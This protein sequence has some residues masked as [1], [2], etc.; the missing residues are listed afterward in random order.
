MLKSKKIL[1]LV[2]VLLVVI[3]IMTSQVKAT[4]DTLNLDD[5]LNSNSTANTTSNEVENTVANTDSNSTLGGQVVQPTTNND[6]SESTN[7][8]PQTGVTE[9]ITVMFF[10][11][12]CVILAIYAY[13]KIRDYKS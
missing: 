6:N 4:S 9:D 13:K 12:V 8:L 3:G 7:N 11:V 5:L 2:I 10:I 1:F